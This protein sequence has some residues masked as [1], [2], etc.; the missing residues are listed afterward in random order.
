MVSPWK[1]KKGCERQLE[2]SVCLCRTGA[3]IRTDAE[4]FFF[5]FCTFFFSYGGTFGTNHTHLTLCTEHVG[6]Y[7]PRWQTTEPLWSRVV[8]ILKRALRR[9][10]VFFHLFI[11]IFL[12]LPRHLIRLHAAAALRDCVHSASVTNPGTWKFRVSTFFPPPHSFW[13][14]WNFFLHI[15]LHIYI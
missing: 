10:Y 13:V 11:I 8:A 5:F 2:S 14:I 9:F 7:Y 4:T 15:Y 6:C 3:R 1:K 12:T